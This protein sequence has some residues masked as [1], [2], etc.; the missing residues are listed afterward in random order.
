MVKTVACYYVGVEIQAYQ[1]QGYEDI[2]EDLMDSHWRWVWEPDGIVLVF[3]VCKTH[4]PFIDTMKLTECWLYYVLHKN[5]TRVKKVLK[6]PSVF[7]Y[8][9]WFTWMIRS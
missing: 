3:E 5:C 6:L 4:T 9:L 8:F 2:E 1:A 7:F